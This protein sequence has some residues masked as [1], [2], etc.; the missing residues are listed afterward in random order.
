VTA[1]CLNVE[2]RIGANVRATQRQTTATAADTSPSPSSN[3]SLVTAID[4]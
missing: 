4:E 2:M 1:T 3:L